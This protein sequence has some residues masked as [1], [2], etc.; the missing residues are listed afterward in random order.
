MTQFHFQTGEQT[1]LLHVFQ[2]QLL[3]GKISKGDNSSTMEPIV[4][5]RNLG[6]F[7]EL[8]YLVVLVKNKD[9][10]SI[11]HMWKMTIASQA[12]TV[13]EGTYQFLTCG[14]FRAWLHSAVDSVSDFTAQRFESQ[15][16]HVTL[17]DLIMKSFL[18]SFSPFR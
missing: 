11:L 1:Q 6:S 5:L 3:T 14:T 18:Q 4:D 2:E 16:G 13:G 12:G 8:F 15:L 17:C 7:E 10:G 9:S